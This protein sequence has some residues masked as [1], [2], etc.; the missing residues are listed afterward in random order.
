MKNNT[1]GESIIFLWR[2]R[3]FVSANWLRRNFHQSADTKRKQAPEK[4][5]ARAFSKWNFAVVKKTQRLHRNL[6]VARNR[7][8][9]QMREVY[10]YLHR[11]STRLH[12]CRSKQHI[13]N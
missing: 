9:L 2:L 11:E 6:A 7:K 12:M 13:R 4:Y 8:I 1:I 10:E 3:S 5:S